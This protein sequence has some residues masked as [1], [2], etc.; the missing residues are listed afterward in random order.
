MEEEDG[1]GRG[2]G[3]ALDHGDRGNRGDCDD[4]GEQDHTTQGLEDVLKDVLGDV[5]LERVLEDVHLRED[6]VRSGW[7]EE[8]A[9]RVR[10]TMFTTTLTPSK[11]TELFSDPIL[12]PRALAQRAS[13]CS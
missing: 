2:R 10:S 9:P 11:T 4:G 3:L 13:H 6:E 8:D 1:V 5:K 7:C 12:S